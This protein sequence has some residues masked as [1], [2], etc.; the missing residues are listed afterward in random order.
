MKTI[1][2]VEDNQDDERLAMRALRTL[3]VESH[4]VIA[5]DGQAAL[6]M[7]HGPDRIVPHL[8]LL[9]LKIPKICGLDVLRQIRAMPETRH[10]PVVILTSSD[11]AIDIEQSFEAGV[12][13]YIRKSIDL[14]DFTDAICQIGN[15]WLSL[16]EPAT[17][18]V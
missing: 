17:A 1:L 13:S 11:E 10:L 16:N 9:D 14:D 18:S 8:V 2:L 5:R 7:L 3:S 15:Y 12:N 4:V 6:E